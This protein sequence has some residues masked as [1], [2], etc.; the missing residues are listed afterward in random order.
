M[1]IEFKGRQIEATEVEVLFSSEPWN[2]YQLADGRCLRLKEILGSVYK[3]EGENNSDGTPV[4][5][6]RTH[7]VMEVK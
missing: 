6:F 3:L 2:E 5:Q 4:Y 1:K 7:K